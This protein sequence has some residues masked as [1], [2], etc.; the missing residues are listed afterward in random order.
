MPTQF[1]K[2][3]HTQLASIIRGKMGVEPIESRITMLRSQKVI[4]DAALAEIYGVTVKRLNQQVKRNRKRFPPDFMFQ[5]SSQE[6]KI[7][8]LQFA[9]SRLKHGGRRSF[10]YA[11][12]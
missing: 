11:F 1:T 4:L 3:R 2:P 5:V 8:R 12:T 10:P 9:T 7:L 6:F